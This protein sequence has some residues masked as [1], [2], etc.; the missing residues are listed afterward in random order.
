MNIKKIKIAITNKTMLVIWAPVKQRRTLG[1]VL[2]NSIKNLNTL[3]IIIYVR[4]KAPLKLFLYFCFERKIKMINN[5]KL[6]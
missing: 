2:M 5:A 3:Y 1:S 6:E 4:N